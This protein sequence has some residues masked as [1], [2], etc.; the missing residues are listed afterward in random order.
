MVAFD[1][2]GPGKKRKSAPLPTSLPNP[3]T[4]VD[5]E[6]RVAVEKI[7]ASK[8]ALERTL[9]ETHS[10]V[11]AHISTTLSTLSELESYAARLVARAEDIAKFSDAD[12][13]QYAPFLASVSV[14][15]RVLR[16]FMDRSAPDL[17]APSSGDSPGSVATPGRFT[18]TRWSER[19]FRV[20]SSSMN[21]RRSRRTATSRS[22]LPS[23]ST[24]R[25]SSSSPRRWHRS[26]ERAA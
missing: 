22:P 19:S 4:I 2:L 20:R 8:A 14:V 18:G 1:A 5:P 25:L 21:S 17:D 7:L 26:G 24:G 12:A 23:S 15:S 9:D 16:E 3:K 6:T 10:D 11:V 13:R